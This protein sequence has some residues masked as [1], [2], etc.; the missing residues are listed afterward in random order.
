MRIKILCNSISFILIIVFLLG[1]SKK[2]PELKTS[3]GILTIAKVTL[4]KIDPYTSNSAPDGYQCLSII[5]INTN[6][7]INPGQ[8]NDFIIRGNIDSSP[9]VM[10]HKTTITDEIDKNKV[11]NEGESQIV[12][13]QQVLKDT[14][15]I[16]DDGSKPIR[17]WDGLSDGQLFTSCFIKSTAN[18]YTLYWPGN[19]PIELIVSK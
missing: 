16:G 8:I 17:Y 2:M 11:T 3:V 4:T 13:F 19:E 18:K 7:K 5:F 9:N 14:Y 10:S 15:V 6:S 12:N 1:C